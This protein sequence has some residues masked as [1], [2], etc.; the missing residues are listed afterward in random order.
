MNHLPSLEGRTMPVPSLPPRL[1]R[2]YVP[3]SIQSPRKNSKFEVKSAAK[4]TKLSCCLPNA[5]NNRAI[6]SHE[7]Q[8]FRSFGKSVADRRAGRR[9]RKK[10]CGG[11]GGK[12]RSYCNELPY[13]CKRDLTVRAR[14]GGGI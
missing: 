7:C 6:V 2:L 13:G 12:V 1:S 10:R 5:D 4:L 8:K 9:C 3:R 14:K 11:K